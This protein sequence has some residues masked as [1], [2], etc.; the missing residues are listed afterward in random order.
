MTHKFAKI[1]LTAAVLVSALGGLMWYSLQQDT[2]YYKHVDE[3]MA[4]PEQWQGKSLQLHGFVVKDTWKR[5]GDTLEYIFDVEN[6]GKVVS[7]SYTGVLPD[8]F[9]DEAEVVLKG[10]LTGHDHFAVD[11]N[12]VMAKCP[13]KYE[14]KANYDLKTG[15]S[16]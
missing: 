12:G 14:E 13:S 7:V 16:N 5:K 4:S 3:V 1:A 10:K 9:K 2:A 11:P 8:T 6:K 15:T